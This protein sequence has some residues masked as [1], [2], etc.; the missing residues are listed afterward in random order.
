MLRMEDKQGKREKRHKLMRLMEL[1]E[2]RSCNGCSEEEFVELNRLVQ[3]L[4]KKY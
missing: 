1:Y 4:S 3:E 2:K